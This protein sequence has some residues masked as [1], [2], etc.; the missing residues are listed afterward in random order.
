MKLV[1]LVAVPIGV[2]TS[3]GPVVARS[4]TIAKISVLGYSCLNFAAAPLKVTAVA[5]WRFLPAI[6]RFAPTLPL[7][8][9]KKLIRGGTAVPVRLKLPNVAR[10]RCQ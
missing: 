3:M 9:K 8:G 4:G 2:V 6:F 1:L 10:I 7:S 5:P